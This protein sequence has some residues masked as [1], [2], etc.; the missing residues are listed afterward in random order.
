MATQRSASHGDEPF[1]PQ[2]SARPRLVGMAQKHPQR[3]SLPATRSQ[4]GTND[5]TCQPLIAG[6]IDE[7]TIQAVTRNKG[8]VNDRTGENKNRKAIQ[9]V[10]LRL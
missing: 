8:N 4:Y 5:Q 6:P 7:A 10:T 9:Q 2:R 1:R 3:R